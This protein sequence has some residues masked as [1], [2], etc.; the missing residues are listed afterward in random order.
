VR[1]FASRRSRRILCW[2]NSF[3]LCIVERA[4]SPFPGAKFLGL[5]AALWSEQA[6]GF[7]QS[8]GLTQKTL[9]GWEASGVVTLQSGSPFTPV[10]S[11][12]GSAYALSSPNLATPNFAPGF[13]CANGYTSG[14]R[15]ARLANCVNPLAYTKD[16]VLPLSTG[17]LSDA[18]GYGTAPRNCVIGPPQKNVDFTLGKTFRLTEQQSL[19]FRADFFNLFNHP[20][21]ANPSATDIENPSSFTQITS[22]VGTPRLIQFSLKYSF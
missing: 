17:G 9:G 10:D 16:A 7:F 11:A 12:G 14:G 15:T 2:E 13:G 4:C 1:G 5:Y 20:S 18:T 8:G 22:V 6:S 19:R 21:F 3:I